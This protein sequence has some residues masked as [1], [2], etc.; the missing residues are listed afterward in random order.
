MTNA[1]GEL[2]SSSLMLGPIKGGK[3]IQK[4]TQTTETLQRTFEIPSIFV[5]HHVEGSALDP[6]LVGGS[7]RQGAAQ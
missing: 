5:Q 6:G 2:R 7:G 1:G 3:N 4:E